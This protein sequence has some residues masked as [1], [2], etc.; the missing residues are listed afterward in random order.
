MTTYIGIFHDNPNT[1]NYSDQV[2]L[3]KVTEYYNESN[4]KFFICSSNDEQVDIPY[5]SDTLEGIINQINNDEYDCG[6]LNTF[7]QESLK[8]YIES[9][10]YDKDSS[11]G[12][13]LFE[14]G[15][16]KWFSKEAHLIRLST[17]L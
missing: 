12:W 15:E 9:T 14:G 8:E 6:K 5:E 1:I 2:I 4:F 16:P 13:I 17:S 11:Y 10:K 7:T 3:R